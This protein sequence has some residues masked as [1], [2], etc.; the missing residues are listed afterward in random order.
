MDVLA[1]HSEFC[2]RENT[3]LDVTPEAVA[4]GT[5]VDYLLAPADV[6]E[7]KAGASEKAASKTGH[8][9]GL[10]IFAIDV[11]GSMAATTEVPALQGE[12]VRLRSL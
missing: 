4:S 9:S 12:C 7:D 10:V 2:G 11:S 6:K 8:G 5:L 3:G 1:K